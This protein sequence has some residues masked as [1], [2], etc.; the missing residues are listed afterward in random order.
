MKY[1]NKNTIIVFISV[2]FL[3]GCSSIPPVDFTVQD[4]GMVNN[5]KSASLVSLTVGFAPQKQQK[6]VE[7]NATIPPIWENG[8][9]EALNRSL[10]FQDDQKVKVNLS[11]R[12][13]EFDIPMGGIDMTTKV[14]AIYEIMDRSDG[15]L[16]YSEL[17]SS[18]GVVPGDYAFLGAARA[19]E[20]W[21]RA[22][23]NN[24]ADFINSL[25]Q[26]DLTKPIY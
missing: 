22:V 7:A 4:V 3:T 11:V 26:V 17:I 9:T 25:E 15:S 1:I 16:L 2:L 19:V 13:V 21:N 12:I 18:K 20:S 14:A 6:I 8:L 24:I 10:I 5:R 23:R